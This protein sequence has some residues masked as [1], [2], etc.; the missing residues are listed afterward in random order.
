[1]T[2]EN[3]NPTPEGNQT[4]FES[5]TIGSND[6]KLWS[7]LSYVPILCLIPLLQEETGTVLRKHARQGVVLMLL[8]ILICILLIPG[9][10]TVLFSVGLL[11]CIVLAIIGAVNASQGRYWRI[12][13]LSDIAEGRGIG[14]VK[15]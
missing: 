7:I 5:P 9:V 10:T 11:I 15:S 3:I 12:P 1:M 6:D 14:K 4:E 8:E 2:D 13:V